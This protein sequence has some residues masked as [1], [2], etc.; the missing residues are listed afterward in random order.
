MMYDQ[1]NAYWQEDLDDAAYN[2][3]KFKE[4]I[5]CVKDNLP[6][7]VLK[8]KSGTR[9]GD[10]EMTVEDHLDF[11]ADSLVKMSELSDLREMIEQRIREIV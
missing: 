10:Y 5:D 4:A 8:S 11:L 2:L 9:M 7:H 3:R 1:D 6:I